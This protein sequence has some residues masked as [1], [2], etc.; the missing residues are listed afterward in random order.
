MSKDSEPEDSV[1]FLFLGP[2]YGWL[3]A[4]CTATRSGYPS[5][6]SARA[7]AELHATRRHAPAWGPDGDSFR[8]VKGEW[9]E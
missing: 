6:E 9:D 3:C 5:E 2:L 7:G 4:V 8:I 1:E